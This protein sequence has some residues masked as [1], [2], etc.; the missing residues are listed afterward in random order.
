MALAWH[1]PPFEHL[2]AHLRPF[3]ALAA[4]GD[5]GSLCTVGSPL[6]IRG[7]CLRLSV[8]ELHAAMPPLSRL[9]GAPSSLR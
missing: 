4:L 8:P 9:T 6:T 3:M 5:A 7:Q 2:F 1:R